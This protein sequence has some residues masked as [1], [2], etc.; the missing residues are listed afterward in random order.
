MV[1]AFAGRSAGGKIKLSAA[2]IVLTIATIP[3]T[4]YKGRVEKNLPYGAE[5]VWNALWRTFGGGSEYEGSSKERKPFVKN[6]GLGAPVL[7]EVC[8]T[9]T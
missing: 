7:P 4:W 8:I 5:K 1:V 6:I 9:R 2:Q 3:N